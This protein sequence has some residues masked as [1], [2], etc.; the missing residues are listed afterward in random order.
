MYDYL[1]TYSDGLTLWILNAFSHAE[2]LER[3]RAAV[4]NNGVGSNVRVVDVSAA[5]LFTDFDYRIEEA[6]ALGEV[7][8]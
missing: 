2:A 8:S 3:A 7:Y 1:A 4:Y 5:D 6:L